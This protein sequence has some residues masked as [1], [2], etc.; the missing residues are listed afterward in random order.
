MRADNC[1]DIKSRHLAVHCLQS[2]GTVWW[3]FADTKICKRICEF[4]GG[5]VIRIAVSQAQSELVAIAF[6]AIMARALFD[7]FSK[8][9][10]AHKVH[11]ECVE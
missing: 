2:N 8:I 5:E 7:V 1:A 9:V 6:I 3:W 11:I 10:I 4:C